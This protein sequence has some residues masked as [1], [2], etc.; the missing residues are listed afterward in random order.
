MNDIYLY[1]KKIQKLL[2]KGVNII[3]PETIF[4]ADDIDVMNISS[5]VVIYPG[6]RIFGSKTSI[7]SGTVI[8]EEAP[9]TIDNCQIA[10]DCRL[11]GGYFK[12]AVVWSN[13]EFGS[14]AHVREGTILEEGSSC[15]HSVGLKQTVLMPYVVTGSLINFC[16]CLMSGGT[17]RKNHSEVGSSY[18]HFNFTPQQDKATASL[19]GDV[20]RGV[21]LKSS[22]IFLGGQGGMVGPVVIEYGTT[23]AAGTIVR[24]DIEIPNQIISGTESRTD[25]AAYDPRI[26]KSINRK[27]RNCFL[28]LGNILALYQWNKNIRPLF[29]KNDFHLEL[30]RNGAVESLEI[31]IKERIQRL[32]D[33]YYK[34]LESIELM[35]VCGDVDKLSE[36]KLFVDCWQAIK[37]NLVNYENYIGDIKKRNILMEKI[38]KSNSQYLISLQECDMET[39]KV[40]TDWLQSI[41]DEVELLWSSKNE[42]GNI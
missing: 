24:K 25:R 37:L 32:D 22:P 8:G 5:S 28:Y 23:I 13:V 21:W 29:T 35:S 30:C 39:Q 38:T 41:V 33:F 20:P 15:A 6:C 3:A 34:V 42:K 2:E 27:L 1:G 36:Q 16:D 18:I 40:G 9:V 12:G 19:I 31:I 14:S 11:K 7:G 10:N 26:Y 17:G 4:I